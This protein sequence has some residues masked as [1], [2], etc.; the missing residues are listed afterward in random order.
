MAEYIEREAAI[1]KIRAE[2]TL[3]TGY[4]SDKEVEDDIIDMLECL[5][6]ADVAPVVHGRWKDDMADGKHVRVCSCC[7]SIIPTDTTID[8]LT[9]ADNRFCYFCGAKMEEA[10]P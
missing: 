10:K 6:A 1:T 7:G 3:S 9:E 2:G 8:Y 4:H 5:P